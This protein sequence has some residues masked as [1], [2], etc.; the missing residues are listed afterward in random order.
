[1]V[2]YISILDLSGFTRKEAVSVFYR[3]HAGDVVYTLPEKYG[4]HADEPIH[5]EK[6][7]KYFLLSK[8]D[9]SKYSKKCFSVT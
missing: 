7:S 9:R 2:K 3:L 6:E 5:L 4:H 8:S 1:M